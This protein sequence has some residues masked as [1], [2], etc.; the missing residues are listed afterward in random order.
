MLLSRREL[1]ASAAATAVAAPAW[2]ASGDGPINHLFTGLSEALLTDSPETATALSLDKG[3]RAALKSRLSDSSW[4]HVSQDHVTCGAWLAKL[5]AI[6]DAG[7]SP[8]AAL[9][10]AVV[11]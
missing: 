1:L 10:K 8:A 2:A 5:N 4:A 6:P 7:L 11:A 9:N 3:P